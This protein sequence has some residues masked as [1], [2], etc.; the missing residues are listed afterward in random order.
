LSR[1]KSSSTSTH[2]L[3]TSPSHSTAAADVSINRAAENSGWAV[4]LVTSSS[5]RTAATADVSPKRDAD[6]YMYG[7]AVSLVTSPS[8]RTAADYES[9]IGVDLGAARK[10]APPQRIRETLMHLSVFTTFLPKFEFASIF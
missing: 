3:V 2:N 4:Y 7:C 1:F 5:H 6:S 9:I 10:H 8:H